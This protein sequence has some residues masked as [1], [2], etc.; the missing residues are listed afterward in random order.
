MKAPTKKK[1]TRGKTNPNGANQYLLDPRQ[2]K[3]WDLYVNPKS[4]TFGNAYQSAVEAGYTDTTSARITTEQWFL[5]KIRRM[6]MLSKAEKVLDE[7]LEID[8]MQPAVGAFGP[9]YDK[10]TKKRVFEM[11][12]HVLKVKQDTAKFVAERLGKNDG[13]SSRNELTGADGKDLPTPIYGGKSSV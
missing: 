13:Y 10:K 1:T 7:T 2:K 12:A 5:E 4:K 11:N 6:N 3:C 9:I 8:P